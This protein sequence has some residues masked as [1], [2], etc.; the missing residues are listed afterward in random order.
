M[1]N[2]ALTDYLKKNNFPIVTKE[3][4]KYL[5]YEGI[6][7]HHVYILKS[8]VIKTSVI[9][10]DGREFNLE[11]INDLE[12]VSLLKDEYSQFIDAPFNI[13]VESEKAEL[14]QIDRVEFWK[15]I[16][17]NFELQIYVKNYYRERLLKSMKRTQQMLMNGKFGAVCTQIY[18]LYD[19]FGVE[20]DDGVLID[21]IV[22]NEEIAHFC[23]INAASSVS[24]I[25]HELKSCG[26]IQMINRKILIKNIELIKDNIIF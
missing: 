10:R 8:G 12:V 4:K 22:T 15:D 16:N 5:L 7:D 11:Y 23:G 1:D 19:K 26:A 24:R 3:Y 18:D 13:R 14:Y 25:M 20:L 21:F 2:T 6:Q 17:Q 9:S